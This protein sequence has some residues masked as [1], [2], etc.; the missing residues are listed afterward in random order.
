M[1]LPDTLSESGENLEIKAD[2]RE[3]AEGL[4]HLQQHFDRLVSKADL[5]EFEQMIKA[6]LR[7]FE[8]RMTLKAGAMIAAFAAFAVALELL[9]R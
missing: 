1:A 3:L 7:E 9:S 5:C 2:T 4:E 6:D 8:S